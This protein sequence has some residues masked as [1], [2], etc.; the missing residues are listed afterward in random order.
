VTKLSADQER[1][2]ALQ[3]TS[4]SIALLTGVGAVAGMTD[5]TPTEPVDPATPDPAHVRETGRLLSMEESLAK[6]GL[7]LVDA[8]DG[9]GMVEMRAK[10]NERTDKPEVP[11]KRLKVGMGKNHPREDVR[12]L[13][14][15]MK[16]LGFLPN[17]AHTNGVFGPRLKRA[18]E[19]LQ[20]TLRIMGMKTDRHG[21]FGKN[22]SASLAKLYKTKHGKKAL[23][24]AHRDLR[25][26]TR[27]SPGAQY[28]AHSKRA[29]DLFLAAARM[30]GLPE[31]WA[32]SSGLHNILEHESDGKVG[33]PNYTYG[34]RRDTIA[35]W[36]AIHR[37]L[38][39]GRITAVSSATGL[40]QLLNYNVDT[41][42][43]K[44]R[45][46]IGVPL[47]EAIGMLNYIAARYGN[48]DIAWHKYNTLHEGY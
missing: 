45:K 34:S 16:E 21:V 46:G 6:A 1:N 2:R 41:Y 40:G 44:G 13:K 14:Q 39:A 10:H 37:E 22:T 4:G 18:V 29:K 35:G 9:L 8:P 48:P 20:A 7:K 47:Q 42:Y 5:G 17:K 32:R 33:I 28:P 26:Y 23:K 24:A 31:S 3:I 38:R 30:A 11:K 27:Y 15:I 19:E 36:R 12:D 25:Q 43:P